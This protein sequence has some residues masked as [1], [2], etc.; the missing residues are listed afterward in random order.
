MLHSCIMRGLLTIFMLA[1]AA[2]S[3]AAGDL[4]FDAI[5][6]GDKPAVEQAWP[7]APKSTAGLLIRQPPSSLLRSAI[8]SRSR[9]CC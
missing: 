7:A 5:A 8:N 2:T 4:L 9:N 6:A 1:F 3:A